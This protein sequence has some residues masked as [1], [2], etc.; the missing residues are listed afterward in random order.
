MT[1]TMNIS[2]VRENLYKLVDE[3]ALEHDPLV[4]K[5]KRHNAVLISE[6]DFRAIEETLYL[7][8]IPGMKESILEGMETPVDACEERLDW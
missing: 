5:G 8:G 1:K 7:H 4:I 2:K 6:E 3:V